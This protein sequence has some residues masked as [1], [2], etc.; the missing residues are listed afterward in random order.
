MER[1]QFG[2]VDQ[3]WEPSRAK[4]LTRLEQSGQIGSSALLTSVCVRRA[5][6]HKMHNLP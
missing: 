1:G 2:G 6:C 3:E 5:G 4:Q